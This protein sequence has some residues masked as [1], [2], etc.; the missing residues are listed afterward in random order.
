MLQLFRRPVEKIF[1]RAGITINGTQP[2]DIS[3]NDD[4]F[5]RRV[6]LSGSLG[7]GESYMRQYWTTQ[8]LEGLFSR[9]VEAGLEQTS[10]RIPGQF[11]VGMLDRFFNQQTP[12][13]SRANAEHHYNLGNDLFFKFLGGYKNYS[14]GYYKIAENLEDAQLAK[15]HRLCEM[16]E[17]RQ[18]DRL[19]DVGGGWGEFANFAATNYGCHVTSINIA[20]EQIKHAREK[21]RDSN[22]EII[23]SDYRDVS[24]T[25]DKIAVVA[26]FT[27]VGYKNYRPFM[28]KMFKLLEPGGKMVM[29]TVGGVE[30][31]TRCEPWTNKYIFPG[32]QIPSME[33]IDQS[34]EGVFRRV[35]EEEFGDDYVLTLR[36]WHRNF[37]EAWP[38][39]SA[40]YSESMRLMFEYFFLS[41][42]GDF[43]A[44]GLLHYHIEFAREADYAER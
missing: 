26:M 44:K 29:E 3:V 30:S 14:C 28:E 4:R 42:A 39:L 40:R 35:G 9:L 34:I 16:L 18:G 20:D 10:K 27:H 32:G 38:S 24:G 6:L 25:Y 11:L 22:V 13:K 12:V 15:M 36:Q 17:L 33:Q 5:Y 2:W 41:V 37:M 1:S 7:L 8:D 21:C 43:R 19:L 31:K 23:K